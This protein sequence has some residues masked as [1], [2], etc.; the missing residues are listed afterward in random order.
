ML[1]AAGAAA[2]GTPGGLSITHGT[3]RHGNG[4]QVPLS[5]LSDGLHPDERGHHRIVLKMIKDLRIF[6][7]SSRVCSL[8]IP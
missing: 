6:D 4:G 8:H 1:L 3:A 7:A 5:L 2:L